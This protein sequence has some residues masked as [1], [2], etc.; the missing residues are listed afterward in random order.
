M[1]DH[2]DPYRAALVAV[3][4]AA[5]GSARTQ[6]GTEL[7]T[8]RIRVVPTSPGAEV[9]AAVPPET[10]HLAVS[11]PRQLRP[12]P[13]GGNTIYGVCHEIGHLVL[14]RVLPP[15]RQLPVVWDE[16]FAHL[17]AVEILL[18]A[19]WAAHGPQLWPDPYPDYLTR[20]LDLPEE[21][22]G[23]LHG[24]I[25]TLE[26]TTGHLRDIA[27]GIGVAGLLATLRSLGPR[28]LRIEELA[29]ALQRASAD[30]RS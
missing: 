30:D 9:L 27:A 21:P 3:A 6:L 19:V 23:L 29:R 13:A 15:G 26:R 10:V 28:Q 14:A 11:D 17:L 4:D 18:P 24:S 2:L 1:V 16:A 12:P 5:R 8:V 25:A 22:D 7:P 20:E